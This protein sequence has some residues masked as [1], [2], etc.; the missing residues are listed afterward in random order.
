M[1]RPNLVFVFVDQ[2][3]LQSCGYAQDRYDRTYADE[4]APHTPNIDQLA[5]ESADFRQ[6]VAGSPICAPCRASLLTGKH[7]S[8]TGMVINELRAMPDPD[9]IGHVLSDNGYHTGYIGKWHLY[10]KDHSERQQFVPPGPYRLGF[11][12]EWKAYNFNHKYYDGFYY[13]DTFD[14]IDVPG[15]EP[16]TQTDLA[17][18]YLKRRRA[19]DDPFA[20]FLSYG[21]PHD[22]WR[23]DN[24]PVNRSITCPAMRRFRIPQATRTATPATGTRNG[25]RSGGKKSGSRTG[26]GSV[27]FTLPRRRAWTGRWNGFSAR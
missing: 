19:S 5:G 11:D 1:N 18:D 20:L 25:T 27:R 16:H 10:G 9:A 23:W 8:S 14:R 6:A 17:I 12:Q 7:T 2:L 21:P 4:P 3:R 13:E 24:C 15:Y 26:F 22:P